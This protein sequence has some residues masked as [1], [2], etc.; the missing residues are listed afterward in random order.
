MF[1]KEIIELIKERY[2]VQGS[3]V[4]NKIDISHN[5]KAGQV[6]GYFNKSGKQRVTVKGIEYA[7]EKIIDILVNSN[8]IS[9]EDKT[10]IIEDIKNEVTPEE[11]I[12]AIGKEIKKP[13]SELVDTV[14]EFKR[15]A[16]KTTKIM[17]ANQVAIIGA[18]K[19]GIKGIYWKVPSQ[20]YKVD[21]FV[22]RKAIYCGM[23]KT[24]AE[25]IKAQ[26]EHDAKLNSNAV[27]DL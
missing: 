2:T 6:S 10:S 14:V 17:E 18:H 12:E 1:D 27:D 16:G 25:A 19:T 8:S 4:V 15:P 9:S 26:K 21:V 24:L 22:K 7:A 23:Y 20:K 3:D 13:E 5:S 11:F